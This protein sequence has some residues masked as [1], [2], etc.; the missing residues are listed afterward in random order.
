M[1]LVLVG[2]VGLMAGGA[3]SRG[4]PDPC[5]RNPGHPKCRT[6]TG[7]SS[8]PPS[9][10][11]PPTTSSTHQGTTTVTLPPATTSPPPTATV[12]PSSTEVRANLWVVP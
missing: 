9:T 11:V 1:A 3:V 7:T 4:K 12:P 5:V 10:S 6:V 2:V 8:P